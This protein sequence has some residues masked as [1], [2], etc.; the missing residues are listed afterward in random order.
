VFDSIPYT[1][2]V[3]KLC[4]LHINPIVLNEILESCNWW[5]GIWNYSS[6]I[7]CTSGL[8]PEALYYFSSRLM[9]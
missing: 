9:I 8:G 4:Q 7:R 6:Y 2:L 3:Q 5:R 1:E